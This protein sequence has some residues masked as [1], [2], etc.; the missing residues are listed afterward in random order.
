VGTL[1]SFRKKPRGQLLSLL[2]RRLSTANA[3][4]APILVNE[5]DP[6]GSEFYMANSQVYDFS[7]RNW[8]RFAKAFAQKTSVRMVSIGAAARSRL[9]RPFILDDVK[10]N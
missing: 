8:V 3:R 9:A 6:G 10:L 5:L 4:S 1:G 7:T 2:L